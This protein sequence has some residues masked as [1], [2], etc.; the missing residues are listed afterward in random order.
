[1]EQ[2]H[3]LRPLHLFQPRRGRSP[4]APQS[5]STGSGAAREKQLHHLDAPP[6]ARPSERG[7]LEKVVANVQAGSGIEQDGG[8][9]DTHAV[10]A[11]DGL[12][13]HGLAVV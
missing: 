5:A 8:E 6:P 10:I 7:A 1:M 2:R 12:M 9:L 4:T 3:D 11:R 13:Q